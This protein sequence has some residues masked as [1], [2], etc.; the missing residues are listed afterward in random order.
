MN[1]N[2]TIGCS[3]AQ[4]NDEPPVLMPEHSTIP[5]P[6][7][8]VEP[9]MLPDDAQ[10]V[11]FESALRNCKERGWHEIAVY[12]AGEHSERLGQSI[13]ERCGVRLAAVLDDAK[14]GQVLG[15]P[16]TK[17]EDCAQQVDAVVLS[18]DRYEYECQVRAQSLNVPVVRP[19]E[20]LEFP[21]KR[22]Q[23]KDHAQLVQRL[24]DSFTGK[25]NLGC[26]SSPLPGWTNIDGGDGL[27]HDVP[28]HPDVIAMDVFE[29]MAAL[30]DGSCDLIT[31]EHFYEHFTLEQGYV[32]ACEWNRLLCPG[33]VV[34]VVT[35]DIEIEA[36]LMLGQH[37]LSSS[38][39]YTEHKQ[40]WLGVRHS[41]MTN[42]FLTSAMLFNFG[43]RL[44]G[45]QFLYD[46]K[47]LRAQ[48]EAAGLLDVTRLKFGQST[49][50]EMMNIDQHDG[51][52]TG[53]EWAKS[54]QL[55]VEAKK[56]SV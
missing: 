9:A 18:T 43:M 46:F 4:T 51:G 54:I 33:G 36:R 28:D 52:E 41:E 14:T 35:P 45:H 37:E 44:D 11:L 55:V 47:T 53:G 2:P 22:A 50:V 29:A 32:M 42:R 16:I 49:H 8:Q 19:Y 23:R 24:R 7:Y 27:W 12:P 6:E 56:P 13:F 26:G 48:L 20:V 38:D 25:L 3:C 1:A 40:R 21:H 5:I 34:R 17:P 31:S 39:E 30:S 15:L 10:R